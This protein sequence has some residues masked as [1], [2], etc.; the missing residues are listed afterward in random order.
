MPSDLHACHA[1]APYARRARHDSGGCA[2]TH[3]YTEGVRACVADVRSRLEPTTPQGASS[4]W[5][6]SDASRARSRHLSIRR[7]SGERR[8]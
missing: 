6:R 1:C 2:R 4:G 5:R 7:I 8:P 3:A